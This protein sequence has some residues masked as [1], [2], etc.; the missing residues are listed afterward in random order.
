[1]DFSGGFS[2]AFISDFSSRSWRKL[3][4]TWAMHMATRRPANTTPIQ[5]HFKETIQAIHVDRRVVGWS[6]GRHVDHP[7]GWQISPWPARKVTD[8]IWGKEKEHLSSAPICVSEVM[9]RDPLPYVTIKPLQSVMPMIGESQGKDHT[10]IGLS[11]EPTCPYRA[12]L[13]Q[14]KP[15]LRQTSRDPAVSHFWNTF[16]IK[17]PTTSRNR[18]TKRSS[19][20]HLVIFQWR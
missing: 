13:P 10:V 1:M 15:L 2:P 4:P 14:S 6:A 17:L 12:R 11:D 18:I 9:C 3:P 8:S 20:F 5:C 7:C 16:Q 19:A